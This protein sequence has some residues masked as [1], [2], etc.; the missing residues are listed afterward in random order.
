MRWRKAWSDREVVRKGLALSAGQ[1]A[2]ILDV[3]PQLKRAVEH[4][5]HVGRA[6]RRAGNVS[7]L[8]LDLCVIAPT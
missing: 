3:D 2:S 8:F 5:E 4:L 7:S 1:Q 6:S